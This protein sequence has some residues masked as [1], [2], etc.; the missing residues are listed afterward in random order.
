[1]IHSMPEVVKNVP[2]GEYDN[3]LNETSNKFLITIIKCVLDY[4]MNVFHY[5][6]L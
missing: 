1:M 3:T 5:F 2:A 4:E 6:Y